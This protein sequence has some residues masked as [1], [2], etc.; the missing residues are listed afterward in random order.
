MVEIG[1]SVEDLFA[2]QRSK[3]RQLTL[4]QCYLSTQRRH[5]IRSTHLSLQ[6]EDVI[7]GGGV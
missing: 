3:G 1:W 5:D 2:A 6:I 7:A 4:R